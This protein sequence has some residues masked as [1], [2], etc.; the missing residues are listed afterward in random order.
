MSN[1]E[2]FQIKKLFNQ[3]DVEL[4]LEDDVNIFIGENGMGK[5]TILNCLY[6]V[7]SGR[8][9]KLD[10]VV[11]EKI[12]I[13]FK[14][15]E[16]LVLERKDLIRYLEENVYDTPR[17]RRMRHANLDNIFSEKE[18]EELRIIASESSF[19]FEDVKNYVIRVSEV[20][21]MPLGMARGEIDR[22]IFALLRPDEYGD[23]KR[24]ISFKKKVEE[25]VEEEILYFPTYRR[26]EE[27][28]SKL[29]LDVDKDNVKNRLIQFGMSDVENRI[30]KILE[31]IRLAAMTGFTK[32]TGVLLKQY[33]DNEFLDG[34]KQNIDEEK[35][36]IALDR[37]G[38]EIETSDKIKIKELV[39]N[40]EIY[41]DNNEHLL[42]LI[43]N[44]IASYE[45]QS[46]Y[47]EKVKRFKDVCNGYLDGKKYVYDESNVTLEIY[48]KNYKKPINIKNLSSGEKQVLSI[49]SK[50]YLDDDKPCI[51]LFDEPELSL[52]IK[53]Q[54]HF[55][56]DI[57]ESKKCK[58]LIAVTHSPFIFENQYDCLAQ[59]MG[60][61]ITEVKG[62]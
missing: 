7:L 22:Y 25:L 9:E 49:F 8:L 1:I 19:S 60:M 59:D 42:N 26:I 11:F 46:F 54:E 33:L 17:Y 47:D 6:G 56:P 13:K 61:C 24:A 55:L 51:I 35:L 32:M 27:D 18:K 50:L 37:I 21:G 20:Y 5:T 16:E 28:M 15:N 57:M 3:Y 12:Q 41:K 58:M 34:K 29:G 45:K 36:N 53:W 48:R 30:N 39:A 10:N 31:T 2:Y 38:E 52:S 14:N 62:E 43:I 23:E 4:F 40:G 44:L